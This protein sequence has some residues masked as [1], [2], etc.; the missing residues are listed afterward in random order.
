[1]DGRASPG[2]NPGVSAP[3][4]A[5]ESADGVVVEVKDRIYVRL[6]PAGR[7]TSFGEGGAAFRRTADGRVLVP[8]GGG[9]EALD[10]AAA[11]TVD[12]W[13]VRRAGELREAMG[14]TDVEWLGERA[15]GLALLEVAACGA[16]DPASDRERFERAYA[17][18][19]PILPPHRYRDVVVLPA[20]GC[21]N[22]ACRFCAF[23][24]DRPFRVVAPEAFRAHLGAV[25]DLFG[26]ALAA[27]DGV[28]LGSASALSL[29]DEILLA[30][31]ADVEAFLGRPRRGTAS[32]L[33][34]DRGR[35]REA[36]EWSRLLEAGLVEATVGLETGLPA[37]REEVGKSPDVDRFV[38]TVGRLKAGG[39]AVSVTVLIGLGGESR[40]AA[41][42]EATLEALD[43]MPLDGADRVYLASLGGVPRPEETRRFREGIRARTG[44]Y[45]IERFAW[46]A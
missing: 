33:D 30:R 43:R 4:R 37:L 31:L 23:Y 41:H 12:A 18:P 40:A 44:D 15:R 28:F 5:R 17:E 32:F 9:Y 2:Q 42:R 20:T 10:E 26:E 45:R 39:L 27:R 46:F 29:S 8:K 25:R 22:H 24:R 6:D 16:H 7:W 35:V 38:E 21:P 3:I 1:M 34:P 14:E 11:A 36:A 19:V 13:V